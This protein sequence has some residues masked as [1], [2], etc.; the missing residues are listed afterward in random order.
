MIRWNLGV[1]LLVLA[2]SAFSNETT[3][4][5]NIL[6]AKQS[7]YELVEVNA[8]RIDNFPEVRAELENYVNIILSNTNGEK[9]GFEEKV[10][11]WK[12]LW[13]DDADDL[14]EIMLFKLLI[15]VELTK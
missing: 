12:Q 11:I 3:S 10:G 8:E 13:T 5:Q 1:G 6:E 14:R 15:D 2:S 4:E 7:I 9:K